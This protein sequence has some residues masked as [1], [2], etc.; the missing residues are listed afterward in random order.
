MKHPR[1]FLSNS[2]MHAVLRWVTLPVVFSIVFMPLV[3][4]VSAQET[5]SGTLDTSSVNMSAPVASEPT[6]FEQTSDVISD[7]SNPP[8]DAMHPQ[9]SS[10]VLNFK[11]IPKEKD[12]NNKLVMSSLMGGSTNLGE[13]VNYTNALPQARTDVATGALLQEVPIILPQGRGGLTPKVSI[14]YNSQRYEDSIAGFGWELSVPY[15]ERVNKNGITNLYA[16]TTN[17]EVFSSSEYGEMVQVGASSEYRTR[18]D[19]G[20]F[21]KSVFTGNSWVLS[22]KQGLTYTYGSI[23]TSKLFDTASTSAKTARWYLDQVK[24][25]NNNTVTYSYIKDANQIYPSSIN[26]GGTS[27]TT[28]PFSVT[29]TRE[30]RPDRNISLK[31]AFLVDTL[32]RINTVAV[33]VSSS[34]VRTYAL[35]YTS[36]NNGIRSMLSSVTLSYINSDSSSGSVPPWQFSYVNDALGAQIGDRKSVV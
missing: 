10:E 27:T 18:T 4:V 1:L 31:Y 28:G 30:I 2:P 3:Q 34:T 17:G 9:E 5:S 15:I 36:G 6:M 7:D 14:Q 19:N 24:D 11:E 8:T 23:D 22:D 26:Y 33:S 20:D 13:Q 29:F 32:Q 12:T 21:I 16:T 35:G 25:Q